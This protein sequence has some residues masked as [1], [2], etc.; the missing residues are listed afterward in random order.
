[1]FCTHK[2]HQMLNQQLNLS[3]CLICIQAEYQDH[4]DQQYVSSITKSIYMLI[5]RTRSTKINISKKRMKN[6][7]R[8]T[9]RSTIYRFFEFQQL[10]EMNW[11][12]DVCVYVSVCSEYIKIKNGFEDLSVVMHQRERIGHLSAFLWH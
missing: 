5:R 4:V 3:V 8:D 1:M 7:R 12:D 10:I 11:I 2:L 6:R 9:I